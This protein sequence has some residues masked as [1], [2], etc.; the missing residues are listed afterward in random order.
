MYKLLLDST[1]TLVSTQSRKSAGLFSPTSGIPA[2]G[3]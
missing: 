2:M 3:P 1:S